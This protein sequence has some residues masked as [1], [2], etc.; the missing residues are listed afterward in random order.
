LNEDAIHKSGPLKDQYATIVSQDEIDTYDA[1]LK[2]KI[3]ND[4]FDVAEWFVNFVNKKTQRFK[5]S[6][7]KNGDISVEMFIFDYLEL[8]GIYNWMIM[9]DG[10][11]AFSDFG[12]KPILKILSEYKEESTPEQT[13]VIINKCLDVYHQR[14]DLS[15]IFIRGG[16]KS[17]TAISS[18]KLAESKKPNL[19][20]KLNEAM[21]DEFSFETLKLLPSFNQRLAYCKE[22]L[23]PSIG[24]GSSRIVFQLT[25][26]ICLK[27][28]KN[29]KGIAQNELEL[30]NSDDYF[31]DNLFPKVFD[32]SDSENY[33]FLV[34]EYVLPAKKSDF[35]IVENVS[36]NDFITIL[37]NLNEQ[38]R[39]TQEENDIY[40]E[41]Y[42]IR[43][44]YDYSMN[45][46]VPII[47]LTRIAN[48]GLVYR[49]NQAT[50]VLLDSGFNKDIFNQYYS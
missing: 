1:Q 39:L 17:L 18:G 14:G 44:V 27:L 21:S 13:L 37:T 3:N 48:Y 50:L 38:Q 6:L 23:G 19:K 36:F 9:P 16:S 15:S 35:K 22:H 29:V 7:N 42:L 40:D 46:N 49:D 45:Y 2:T 4:V 33:L 47:E 25:D 41:S 32:E 11:D 20:S 30:R 31:I 43:D 5:V 8:T 28:A 12:I 26:E 24:Q 34:S 10:S